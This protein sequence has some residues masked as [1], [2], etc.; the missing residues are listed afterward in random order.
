M[1]ATAIA[2]GHQLAADICFLV[3]VILCLLTVVAHRLDAIGGG[4]APAL[5]LGAVALG[6]LLL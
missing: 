3:A 5:A 2:S 1:F 4:V 6:L